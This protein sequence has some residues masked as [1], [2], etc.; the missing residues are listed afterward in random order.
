M[1]PFSD[2][3]DLVVWCDLASAGNMGRIVVCAADGSK[4]VLARQGSPTGAGGSYG[5]IDAWPSMNS[6]GRVSIGA[7]TPGAGWTSAHLLGVLCGP[8][9]A[10]SP[11]RSPGETVHVGDFGPAGASFILC[12]STA[13]QSVAVPP[14]G[15]LLIGPAPIATLTGL[16]PYPGL[17]AP[18]LLPLP[19]PGNPAFAGASLHFQA[20]ALQGAN[21]QLTNRATTLIQ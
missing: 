3:G 18:H 21:L 17:S 4:T 6:N 2:D 5:S 13:A 12:V 19:I 16:V 8:A 1:T 7:G 11:C 9:V 15:T 20:L 10:S 14:Y